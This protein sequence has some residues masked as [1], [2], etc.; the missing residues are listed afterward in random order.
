M[1]IEIKE[2]KV[3]YNLYLRE[4]YTPEHNWRPCCALCGKELELKDI[5]DLHFSNKH[6][7]LCCSK[8]CVE[9]QMGNWKAR[10]SNDGWI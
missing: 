1:R 6:L 4:H 5:Q 9:K 7:D 8:K 2:G 3:I 10:R